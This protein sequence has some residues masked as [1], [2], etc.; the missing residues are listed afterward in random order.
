MIRMA[1]CRTCQLISG[2]GYATVAATSTF[3]PT[4]SGTYTFILKATDAC[5]LTDL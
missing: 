2:T 1:I 3:T 4:G 5:G